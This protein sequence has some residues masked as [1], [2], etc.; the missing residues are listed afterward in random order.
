M[1]TLFASVSLLGALFK[2]MHWPG[3]GILL[4]L[5]IAGFALIGLP[6]MALLRYKRI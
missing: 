3:A 6:L 4:V 5:G 2:T 1:G